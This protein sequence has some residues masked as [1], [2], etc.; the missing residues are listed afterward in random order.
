MSEKLTITPETTL[1]P[2]YPE[3]FVPADAN[4]LTRVRYGQP[5]AKGDVVHIS[6]TV[7]DSN[8]VGRPRILIEVWQA[9]AAGIY[10]HPNE[11]NSDALDSNFDGWGRMLTRDDG[12]YEFLT[13]FPGEQGGR[14][15][16]LKLSLFGTGFDRLQTAMYFPDAPSLADDPVLKAVG[17]RRSLLIAEEI[18]S[19]HEHRTFC[20]DIHMRG[21]SETPFFVD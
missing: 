11:E 14:A 8:G 19:T 9:N 15:P 16:H 7:F 4:D 20:F 2:F 13:I 12:S 17:N 21:E 3:T 18:Q 1:G 10:R 5:R 6:G